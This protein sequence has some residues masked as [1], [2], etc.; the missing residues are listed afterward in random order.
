MS[1]QFNISKKITILE[2]FNNFLMTFQ[3]CL[4][5]HEFLNIY[6]RGCIRIVLRIQ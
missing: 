5:F 6:E 3:S 1:V 4:S 2:R